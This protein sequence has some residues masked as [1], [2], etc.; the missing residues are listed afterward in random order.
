MLNSPLNRHST[1][2]RHHCSSQAAYTAIEP[3]PCISTRATP[4]TTV[5]PT[6][7]S[8]IAFAPGISTEL[9]L[10]SNIVASLR[11]SSIG[12]LTVSSVGSVAGS[13]GIT[14]TDSHSTTTEP[15]SVRTS[16]EAAIVELTI[17]TATAATLGD[18]SE[19][20]MRVTIERTVGSTVAALRNTG[21]KRPEAETVR[22][23]RQARS[24]SS[25][26]READEPIPLPLKRVKNLWR[27]KLRT[28]HI[29]PSPRSTG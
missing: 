6:A 21:G 4:D 28:W 7:G 11:T 26:G 13:I 16:V 12:I 14:V 23:E 27:K 15:A 8:N 9:N 24:G 2:H 29:T 5:E 10:R 1:H 3:A 20:N 25:W 17:G 22:K 19:P 18:H